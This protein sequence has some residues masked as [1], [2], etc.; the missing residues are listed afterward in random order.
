MPPKKS[1]ARVVPASVSTSACAGSMLGLSLRPVHDDRLRPYEIQTKD[2]LGRVEWI[3][4]N[5]CMDYE[6]RS[7]VKKEN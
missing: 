2:G 1:P 3:H 4:F 5:Y 7:K 6:R